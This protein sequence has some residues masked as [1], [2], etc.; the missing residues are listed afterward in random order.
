MPI[1]SY[2]CPDGHEHEE[3]FASFADAEPHVK[4]HPCPV[5]DC[6]QMASKILGNVNFHLKGHF[7]G[8]RI[9]EVD[10]RK[11]RQADRLD[12]KVKSGELTKQDVAKMAKIRDKFAKASPY[13][14][15]P[16]KKSETSGPPLDEVVDYD[17][18]K[19][20]DEPFIGHDSKK[21]K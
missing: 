7:P 16:T 13:L 11:R 15:D 10:A 21:K 5:K 9:K 8:K 17:S 19:P 4:E 3:Y 18:S 1:Y 20:P 6:G 14:T 2:E 12:K